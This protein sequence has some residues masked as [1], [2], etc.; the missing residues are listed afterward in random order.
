MEPWVA[1]VVVPLAIGLMTLAGVLLLHRRERERVRRELAERQADRLQSKAEHTIDT[2]LAERGL[3]ERVQLLDQRYDTLV[4][5]ID[6]GEQKLGAR[7]DGLDQRHADLREHIG[8]ELL[9]RGEYVQS[10]ARFERKIDAIGEHIISLT[11]SIGAQN[12][13]S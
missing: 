2:A 5:R 10:Q 9:T 13:T 1:T 6:A 8:R 3:E 12:P 4:A 11:R 7:V